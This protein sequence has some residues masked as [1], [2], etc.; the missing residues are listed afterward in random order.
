MYKSFIGIKTNTKLTQIRNTILIINMFQILISTWM[1]QIQCTFFICDMLYIV[2]LE[3]TKLSF[4]LGVMLFDYLFWWSVC[5]CHQ[6]SH[7]YFYCYCNFEWHPSTPHPWI[8]NQPFFKIHSVK[9]DVFK[10]SCTNIW[11]KICCPDSCIT[12]SLG[13]SI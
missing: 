4:T 11:W 8:I 13:V 12:L 9:P 1:I 2:C 3:E 7:A 6:L 5:K 10:S